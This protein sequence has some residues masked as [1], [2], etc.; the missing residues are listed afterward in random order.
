MSTRCV[1]AKE[2]PKGYKAIYCHSSGYPDGVGKM[3]KEHYADPQKLDKLIGLGF[4]SSLREEIGRK[5]PFLSD[6]PKHER[7]TSAYFRDR[8]ERGDEWSSNR[9]KI[10]KSFS[11]LL[12][13][14][15][16]DMNYLYIYRR[17]GSWQTIKI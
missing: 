1:I 4:I 7:M 17:N 3:L 5:H 15:R 10:F 8:H 13:W 9:P 11:D 6:D 2:T 12:D 14:A 16:S